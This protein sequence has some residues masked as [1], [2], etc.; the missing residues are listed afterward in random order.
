MWAIVWG[1]LMG[2]LQYNIASLNNTG[3]IMWSVIN[4][5]ITLTRDWPVD[6]CGT[7]DTMLEL[8]RGLGV[9]IWIKPWTVTIV[10]VYTTSWCTNP[11]WTH[12]ARWSWTSR[13]AAILLTHR[14]RYLLYVGRCA[15]RALLGTIVLLKC[16]TLC[17]ANG[18]VLE[19]VEGWRLVFRM[20]K[21]VNTSEVLWSRN[22]FVGAGW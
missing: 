8:F 18:L 11:T 9:S 15:F 7:T 16:I 22:S 1:T 21:T 14:A 6:Q 12:W 5:F 10:A 2:F 3:H 20:T 13:C 4:L 19:L 17:L